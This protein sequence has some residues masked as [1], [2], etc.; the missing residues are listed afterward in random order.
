VHRKI[1]AVARR[2]RK[3]LTQQD[4][5]L[6]FRTRDSCEILLELLLIPGLKAFKGL[7]HFRGDAKFST[8]AHSDRD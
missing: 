3:P 5:R 8:L 6:D 7:A 1:V 4:V 2:I